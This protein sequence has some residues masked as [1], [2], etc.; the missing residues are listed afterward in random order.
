MDQDTSLVHSELLNE[1]ML[2][3]IKA[4]TERLEEEVSVMVEIL[5]A[6]QQE[7]ITGSKEMT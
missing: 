4:S 7:L 5:E 6:L 3:S 1:Q 2:V